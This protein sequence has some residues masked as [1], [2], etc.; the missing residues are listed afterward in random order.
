MGEKTISD[1]FW[2]KDYI[3]D[4]NTDEKILFLYLLTNEYSNIIGIYELSTIFM[5][6]DTGIEKKEIYKILKRFQEDDKIYFFDNKWVGIK[7]IFE[8]TKKY[9]GVKIE[10]GINKILKEIPS[11]I[12]EKI[13]GKNYE[14]NLPGKYNNRSRIRNSLRMRVLKRDKY[15]CQICGKTSRVIQLEVD[16]I[17]PL[18]K[19]GKTTIDNLRTL[20]IECNNGRRDK[21]VDI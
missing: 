17:K 8:Y 13:L 14:K 19:D 16:H 18:S 3:E 2:R 21:D 4:L 20:C 15:R 10:R 9:A 5:E 7:D 12:K 1:G 6:L 11:E